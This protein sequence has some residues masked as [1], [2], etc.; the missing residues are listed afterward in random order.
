MLRL[1]PPPVPS[2]PL[3]LLMAPSE[4]MESEQS[5]QPPPAGPP[6]PLPRPPLDT[7]ATT[8]NSSTANTYNTSAGAGAATAAAPRHLCRDRVHSAGLYGSAE[9]RAGRARVLAARRRLRDTSD[10]DVEVALDEDYNFDGPDTSSMDEP[11]WDMAEMLN[12]TATRPPR[13]STACVFMIRRRELILKV[14]FLRDAGEGFRGSRALGATTNDY[15]AAWLRQHDNITSDCAKIPMISSFE[16]MGHQVGTARIMSAFVGNPFSMALRMDSAPSLAEPAP[17]VHAVS[18]C[19][20]TYGT[21][22]QGPMPAT[23]QHEMPVEVNIASTAP[24]VV[25]WSEAP[26]VANASTAPEV[27]HLSEAPMVVDIDKETAPIM[28][29]NKTAVPEKRTSRRICGMN[30]IVFYCVLGAIA[31][32][33]IAV[34]VGVGVGTRS[35]Q[36]GHSTTFAVTV[37]SSMTSGITVMTSTTSLATDTPSTTSGITVMPSTTSL[38]TDTPS[39]TFLDTDTPSTTSVVTVTSTVLPITFENGSQEIYIRTEVTEPAEDDD[40]Y[41]A[42]FCIPDS[43][44]I[45]E[46]NFESFS[47]WYDSYS[48]DVDDNELSWTTV[49]WDDDTKS[50]GGF[51][52]SQTTSLVE[53]PPHVYHDI[54]TIK[55]SFKLVVTS[56][57]ENPYLNESLQAY[58]GM[59]GLFNTDTDFDEDGG[60]I[61]WSYNLSQADA[62]YSTYNDST[63]T[64]YDSFTSL[65][66]NDSDTAS[67]IRV[68]IK[69]DATN[70]TT[71]LYSFAIQTILYL[72]FYTSYCAESLSVL[73]DVLKG[74]DPGKASTSSTTKC[75]GCLTALYCVYPRSLTRFRS[76]FACTT[77]LDKIALKQ[78]SK[79][80]SLIF[81]LEPCFLHSDLEAHASAVEAHAC[82][83]QTPGNHASGKCATLSVLVLHLSTTPA[84]LKIESAQCECIEVL[85]GAHNALVEASKRLDLHVAIAQPLLA[86]VLPSTRLEIL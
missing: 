57:V 31:I 74:S 79:R 11:A 45:L 25:H 72:M 10:D 2:P 48:Y 5:V 83:R 81:D 54:N 24:E 7:A 66:Y 61:V 80:V 13:S 75:P 68:Y 1:P 33:A 28:L 36:P 67:H 55:F 27:V 42:D 47:D 71:Y 65:G 9:S 21:L 38:A 82:R 70:I 53:S 34:G 58:M 18:F 77:I 35:N 4:V 29:G 41:M 23:P 46:P 26:M 60:T 52:L 6:P 14:A 78:H 59:G 51:Y 63:V 64:V 37:T 49:D 86:A 43:N 12:D 69:S 50:H 84:M 30:L 76:D 85:P 20:K 3:L 17:G 15:L 40:D 44:I 16:C 62:R 32:I 39:T 56:T 19:K 73:T 8:H 22:R